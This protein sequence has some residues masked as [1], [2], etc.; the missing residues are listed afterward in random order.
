MYS[1][2]MQEDARRVKRQAANDLF[3]GVIRRCKLYV[4]VKYIIKLKFGQMS[5]RMNEQV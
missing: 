2:L 1:L 3:V 5:E 4:S